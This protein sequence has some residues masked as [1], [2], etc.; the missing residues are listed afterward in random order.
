[1][2]MTPEREAAY[3]IGNNVARSDLSPPAQ[4]E[5]DRQ[6]RQ[7]QERRIA[8]A[9]APVTPVTPEAK[10][11][12]PAKKGAGGAMALMALGVLLVAVSL[13]V[14]FTTTV[15]GSLGSLSLSRA[16]AIC[17]SSLGIFAQTSSSTASGVCSQVQTYETVCGVLLIAGIVVALAG[18]VWLMIRKSA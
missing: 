4:A 3:A 14:R 8:A 12:T 10:P 9:Q 13:L 7:A 11:A 5:Y 2:K 18:G 6:Q 1:M 17:S 15:T 16:N